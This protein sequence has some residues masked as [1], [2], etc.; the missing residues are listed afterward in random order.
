MRKILLFIAAAI[1]AVGAWAQTCYGDSIPVPRY[2]TDMRLNQETGTFRFVDNFQTSMAIDRQYFVSVYARHHDECRFSIL[3]GSRAYGYGLDPN[4]W[5]GFCIWSLHAITSNAT[6]W[7]EDSYGGVQTVDLSQH[8][9]KALEKGCLEIIIF[10]NPKYV[11]RDEIS[12]VTTY[13]SYYYPDEPT[14]LVSGGAHAYNYYLI[15]YYECDLPKVKTFELSTPASTVKYGD[16]IELN[17]AV[18][19]AGQ[20]RVV[21]SE[22]DQPDGNQRVIYDYTLSASEAGAGKIVSYHKSF[23]DD[24]MPATRYY[25]VALWLP[26][27]K[28][29]EQSTSLNFQYPLVINSGTPAYYS[30]GE[31]ITVP[32]SDCG[33]YSVRTVNNVPVQ[34]EDLGANYRLTMPACAVWLNE[35]IT[36]YTVQFRDY[37]NTVLQTEKVA[38]GSDATPPTPPTHTGMTFTGWDKS[39]TNIRANQVIRATYSMDGVEAKLSNTRE[40]ARQGEEGEL[41]FTV[42]N[43]SAIAARAWLQAAWLDDENDALTFGDLSGYSD[44]TADEVVN[45]TAKVRKITVLPT[46]VNNYGHRARYFRLRVRMAGSSN[47]IYS[48]IVRVATYYP[49]LI[50]SP[51]G[52]GVAESILENG[53]RLMASD[54]GTIY[55][56]PLDTIYATVVS[57]SC[58]PKFEWQRNSF[59]IESGNTWVVVPA[60]SGENMLTIS[61]EKHQVLFYMEGHHDGYWNLIHGEGVYE[62]QEIT[63]GEAATPPDIIAE[64]PEGKLFRGWKARGEYADDAYNYVTEDMIFDALL[65]DNPE[66]I[67][68]IPTPQDKARKYMINGQIYIALPDGKV[69]NVLG[70]E[71]R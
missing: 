71:V 53:E 65:E 18:Q 69:Y 15:N 21:F 57:R 11:T 25:H 19:A 58:F 70:T 51:D 35:K 62:P 46:G 16:N 26:D 41:V 40:T 42:K 61:R 52:K 7:A 10:V 24:D 49:I 45:G 34:L 29:G 14:T 12:G 50:S 2:L 17:C 1:M 43:Q 60:G 44:F 38:C 36:Q 54:N 39:Y 6:I 23:I 59:D 33:A 27:G 20:A 22:S 8:I 47:D 37:D 28:A 48:N 13:N 55:A 64:V 4:G 5:D 66:G 67:E 32:K 68:Q 56:R 9:N 31:Q 63:C 3:S 30:P